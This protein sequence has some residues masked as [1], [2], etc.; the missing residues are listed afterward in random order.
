M[1]KNRHVINGQE[2]ETSS[3][4]IHKTTGDRLKGCLSH[5]IQIKELLH[6]TCHLYKRLHNQFALMQ[7]WSTH[8]ELSGMVAK[9]WH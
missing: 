9:A 4:N 8:F 5:Y 6:K 2:I 1:G 3:K 7:K